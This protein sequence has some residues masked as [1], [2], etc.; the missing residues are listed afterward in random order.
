MARPVLDETRIHPAIRDKVDA[1]ER[2][3]YEDAL[4]QGL[5]SSLP[6]NTSSSDLYGWTAA[7]TVGSSI[8]TRSGSP[9]KVRHSVSICCSPP[10]NTPA[11]VC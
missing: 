4:K 2:L 1:G 11:W 9:I 5:I 3:T 8:M 10:D 7:E 6:A